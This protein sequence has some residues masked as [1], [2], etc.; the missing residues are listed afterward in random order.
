M[1]LTLAGFI[2]HLEYIQR[3]GGCQPTDLIT[4]RADTNSDQFVNLYVGT[5]RVLRQEGLEIAQGRLF[6]GDFSG[7]G[8]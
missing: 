2:K 7:K 6:A 8:L 4:L 3:Q 1:T 5:R